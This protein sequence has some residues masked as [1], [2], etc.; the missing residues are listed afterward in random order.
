MRGFELTIGVANV[1]ALVQGVIYR[2]SDAPGSDTA[3][4]QTAISAERHLLRLSV[5]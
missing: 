3:R 2:F 4:S 1:R 5:G